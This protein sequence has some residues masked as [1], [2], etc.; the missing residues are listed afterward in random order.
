M[1]IGSKGVVRCG[2]F[3]LAGSVMTLSGAVLGES[4]VLPSSAFRSGTNESEYRTDVRILNQGTVAVTVNATF[5]DQ[6]SRT[7]IPA[8]PVRVEA[9]NQAAFDNILQLL[10]GRTL[11]NGA[12]GPI[13]FDAT[14]PVLVA[15][16]VNNV[17]ACRSG[18]ISGQWLPAIE[19]SQGLKAGVIGQLAV[20]SS[21]G[22]GY[23]TNL[24]VMNPTASS[25]TAVVKVRT[26]GG[27]LLATGTIGPLGANGFAQVPLESFSGVAG[28]TDTNLWLEFTSDQPVLAYATIL[29]NVSGDPFAV[30]AARDVPSGGAGPQEVT[31]TL[32]G[33]VPLVMVRI[34]AGT[35]QMG[36]PATERGRDGDETLHT[37]TLTQDYYIG[38]Y[39]V[40]QAQWQAVMGSNPSYFASCGGSCPVEE[41]SWNDIRES[42]GFLAKLNQLL[43]TTKFRLPSEAE[44]ERAARGG[45]QT[46]FS[47]GDALDGNDEC[48]ASA[49]AAP[50]AWWCSNSEGKTHAAG[51]K[52]ANPYGL[53]DMHGNVLE[54]VEDW[55][56]DYPASAQT[57]P[58]GPGTGSYKQFRG[59]CWD[60]KLETA[61]SAFRED[62]YPQLRSYY[63]G[64][65]LARS[66]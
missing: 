55:H 28:T 34:P 5:Y 37:V 36:S 16:S 62:Y 13:R 59:G 44:W 35:F 61:R 43:G 29:H 48:G 11:A 56:G 54:W 9:R 47:F 42:T 51:T 45:T 18:A 27:A 39:E 25:A 66:Q 40:T 23:R 1:A 31:F 38:K 46:R 2:L 41:V 7:A 4:Y 26:G 52:G 57:D 8:S 33:G 32:P 17:N 19:T 6:V 22:S 63:I 64:F 50:N 10:F 60:Y 20:S 21:T 14:G 3:A 49:A 12:Y 65:R 30:V 24:V 58:A 15:S 53:F